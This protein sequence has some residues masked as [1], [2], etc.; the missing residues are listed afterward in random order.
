MKSPKE[1]RAWRNERAGK[2][3]FIRIEA[4]TPKMWAEHYVHIANEAAIRRKFFE[5]YVGPK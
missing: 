1:L 2:L 4:V 3:R 5:M